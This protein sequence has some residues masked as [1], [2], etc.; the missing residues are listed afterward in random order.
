MKC[1]GIVFFMSRTLT[2]HVDKELHVF[3]SSVLLK[4]Q[5]GITRPVYYNKHLSHVIFQCTQDIF[6]TYI[7]NFNSHILNSNIF[8]H[9]FTL[10]YVRIIVRVLSRKIVQKMIQLWNLAKSKRKPLQTNSDMDPT[11]ICP[12]NA[13]W[14]PWK[15][16][17]NFF[18]RFL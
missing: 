7:N 1:M 8:V 3:S 15:P 9:F 5:S 17:L 6:K 2:A 14:L 11:S 16:N 4:Y 18:I 10:H 13:F 12:R